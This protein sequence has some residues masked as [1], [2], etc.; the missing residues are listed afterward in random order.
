VLGQQL[1]YIVEGNEVRDRL[2]SMPAP[3]SRAGRTS[4]IAHTSKDAN[5]T[6]AHARYLERKFISPATLVGDLG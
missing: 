4:G 2:L 6:K 3:R 1:A 5:L